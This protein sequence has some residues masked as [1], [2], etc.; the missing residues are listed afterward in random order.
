MTPPVPVHTTTVKHDMFNCVSIPSQGATQ[1]STISTKGSE[2]KS[3]WL[4]HILWLRWLS[5][6]TIDSPVDQPHLKCLC[7]ESK[8]DSQANC[9]QKCLHS[10]TQ[11]NCWADH[12]E[13]EY[14]WQQR[15]RNY[16]CAMQKR[17]QGR[18]MYVCLTADLYFNEVDIERQLLSGV[19]D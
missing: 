14:K 7:P 19:N 4:C 3:K 2:A 8:L 12:Q 1:V 13:N 18:H 17:I 15:S 5:W 10:Q 9:D 16:Q 11:T 6:S